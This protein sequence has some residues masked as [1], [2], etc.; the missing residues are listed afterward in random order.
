[1]SSSVLSH[2]GVHTISAA[3]AGAFATIVTHP[4]DVIKTKVQ[5]RQE[6]RYHG[7]V[8]TVSTIWKQRGVLGFFDGVSLRISRKIFSSAIGWA[9]YEG[10]LMIM[11]T[12]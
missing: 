8:Q 12:N 1:M 5:V 6:Q 3:S 10:L 11:R 9:V 4:F 7:L 2:V